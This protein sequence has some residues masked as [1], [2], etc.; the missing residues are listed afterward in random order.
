MDP[1]AGH[2]GL[3][4]SALVAVVVREE[5]GQVLVGRIPC[6]QSDPMSDLVGQ[7]PSRSSELRRS[8]P[9]IHDGT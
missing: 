4:L 7:V 2:G 8:S 5:T 6:I 1:L 3:Y 9:V